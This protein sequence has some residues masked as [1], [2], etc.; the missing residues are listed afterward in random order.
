[1]RDQVNEPAQRL[2][3]AFRVGKILAHIGRQQYRPL[4]QGKILR[5]HAAI[6]LMYP[7]R[8]ALLIGAIVLARTLF[9]P[10]KSYSGSIAVS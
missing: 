8:M 9:L 7:D 2:I 6:L 4:F 10:V 3:H 5:D 1:M